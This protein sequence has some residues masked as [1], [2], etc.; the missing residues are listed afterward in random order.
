MTDRWDMGRTR[1]EILW[2]GLMTGR[3]APA[4]KVTRASAVLA[5]VVMV[6]LVLRWVWDSLMSVA[7]STFWSGLPDSLA[8]QAT[9][10]GFD[11]PYPIAAAAFGVLALLG[12]WRIVRTIRNPSWSEAVLPGVAA[13]LSSPLGHVAD[14]GVGLVH[15]HLQRS[16]VPR[17]ESRALLTLLEA[18][19]RLGVQA[20][21]GRAAFQALVAES[22]GIPM[23]R[24]PDWRPDLSGTDLRGAD[25]RDADLRG[26]RLAGANLDGSQWNGMRTKDLDL[27]GA[28]LKNASILGTA[29][30]G[31]PQ[32]SEPTDLLASDPDRPMLTIDGALVG[33]VDLR[34]ARLRTPVQ[35]AITTSMKREHLPP[36]VDVTEVHA[37]PPDCWVLGC[38]HL[39]CTLDVRD[40][41]A[42]ELGSEV[43]VPDLNQSDL[44]RLRYW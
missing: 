33:G 6:V 24:R 3:K 15:S 30:I 26:W 27:E 41:G 23:G 40:R 42:G 12:L 35:I 38:V 10:W 1:G 43:P 31:V 7:E 9:A 29:P 8:A 44:W 25:L 32:G 20:P 16:G 37:C 18:H 5:A 2:T 4:P 13:M 19:A 11:R 39:H 22:R 34:G 14:Q 36:S 28:S 17:D 21:G